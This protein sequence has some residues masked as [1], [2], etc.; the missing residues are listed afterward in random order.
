MKDNKTIIIHSKV[1][2]G[3]VGSN[4]TS[5][6]LQ[7][8]GYDVVTVPTVLYSNHLEYSTV[9]GGVITELMFEDILQGILKLNILNEV[10]TILTGF[11]GSAEQ[12]KITAKFIKNLK[13]NNPNIKYICD[14][15][16]GDKGKGFYV[17]KGVPEAMIKHLVPLADILTPNQFEAQIIIDKNITS[18]DGIMQ[19]FGKQLDL[20]RQE[21]IITGC[22]FDNKK[23]NFIY[24]CIFGKTA[25]RAIKA[26]KINVHPPG[27]GELFTAHMYLVLLQNKSME[28]AVM[29][30]GDILSATLQNMWGESRREF[31]LN[32]IL[33][34]MNILKQEFTYLDSEI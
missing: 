13:Q 23:D 11:I 28:Q 16:M 34:S 10:S 27:T 20:S 4:T 24:N 7:I 3:Y 30:A 25:G 29:L 18:L 31:E 17:S 12:V 5:L 1:S 19:Q 33:F 8:R 26:K 15:V 6:V 14:P 21:I 32:D 22:N 9:G 2:Y